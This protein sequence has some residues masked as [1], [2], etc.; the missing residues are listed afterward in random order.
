MAVI[1]G[2]NSS[3]TEPASTDLQQGRHPPHHAVRHGDPALST[4]GYTQ[5][6][7]VCFLDDRQ[8]LFAANFLVK[9]MG[10][11]NIAILHDNSTYAQGLAEATKTVPGGTWRH[12]VFYDAINP[13]DTDFSPT[14]TKHQ[15]CQ[16]GRHLL[17]RLLRP[18]WPA[19]EAGESAG[20]DL[21]MDRRQRHE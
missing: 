4:K 1:G 9:D 2:Y 16:P 21:C 3:A 14:L 7:R 15:G 8:G 17:H 20:H 18:G 13:K 12:P 10:Y 6:F 19:A 11:K 5:F